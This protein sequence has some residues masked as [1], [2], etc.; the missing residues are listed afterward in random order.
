MIDCQSQ[1]R[2]TFSVA[3]SMPV[4]SPGLIRLEISDIF[5]IAV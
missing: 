4:A 1:C 3:I 2:S 5:S